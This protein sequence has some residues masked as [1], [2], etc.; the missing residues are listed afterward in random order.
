MTPGPPVP[1]PGAGGW[2]GPSDRPFHGVCPVCEGLAAVI[3]DRVGPHLPGG[4]DPDHPP[5]G[6]RG[7]RIGGSS[8]FCQLPAGHDTDPTNP[9]PDTRHRAHDS[10]GDVRW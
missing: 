8:P 7:P 1:C 10:W 4:I 5:C 6:R 2:P 3:L 9:D